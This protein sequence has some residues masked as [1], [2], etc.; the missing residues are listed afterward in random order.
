MKK[1]TTK[2]PRK[3]KTPGAKIIKRELASAGYRVP[4]PKKR[5]YGTR[6]EPTSS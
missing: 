2:T 1:P 3:A 5:G 4:T 6:N